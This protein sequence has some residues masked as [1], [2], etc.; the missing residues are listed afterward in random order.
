MSFKTEVIEVLS[1]SSSECSG[2]GQHRSILMMHHHDIN[3]DSSRHQAS[4]NHAG[5]VYTSSSSSDEAVQTPIHNRTRTAATIPTT[6]AST[7]STNS[8]IALSSTTL[9]NTTDESSNHNNHSGNTVTTTN[10]IVK[11]ATTSSVPTASSSLTSHQSSQ[12]TCETPS[13]KKKKNPIEENED[14]S[15]ELPSTSQK[16]LGRSVTNSQV[17][18]P[19]QNVHTVHMPPSSPL[20]AKNKTIATKP[21]KGNSPAS[22][23]LI[24]TPN[25]SATSTSSSSIKSASSSSNTLTPSSTLQTKTTPTPLRTNNN[26]SSDNPP[27]FISTPSS[28]NNNN[29]NNT[30]LLNQTPSSS[31]QYSPSSHQTSKS[32]PFHTPPNNQISPH[33]RLYLS[34]PRDSVTRTTPLS[35]SFDSSLNQHASQTDHGEHSC[36]IGSMH[37]ATLPTLCPKPKQFPIWYSQKI[38]QCIWSPLELMVPS[39]AETCPKNSICDTIEK[40]EAFE[41]FCLKIVK[42]PD[43]YRQDK[44]LEILHMFNLDLHQAKRFIKDHPMQITSQPLLTQEQSLKVFNALCQF[45]LYNGCLR[46][47]HRQVIPEVPYSTLICH[48]FLN[49]KNK[50]I[51]PKSLTRII[52]LG[53]RSI[54]QQQ[55]VSKF[56]NSDETSEEDEDDETYHDDNQSTQPSTLQTISARATRASETLHRHHPI[57]NHDN[58]DETSSSSS[59]E[60]VP[61]SSDN[62]ES[63]SS[64]EEDN[65]HDSRIKQTQ[66]LPHST[67]VHFNHSLHNSNNTRHHCT[68]VLANR[69]NTN[70]L[71]SSDSEETDI[72]SNEGENYTNGHTHVSA[73]EI[74]SYGSSSSAEEAMY[75]AISNEDSSSTTEVFNFEHNQMFELH[76]PTFE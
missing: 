49:K 20:V 42:N 58:E 45:Y 37:Q 44:A 2:I 64:S 28:S 43:D 50:T 31:P 73:S 6:N 51:I 74:N 11:P 65:Q 9:N 70:Y 25:A 19:S 71:L 24:T 66:S 26:H 23:P 57:T 68:S 18:R 59:D 55:Q 16:T 72:F 75:I 41:K 36:K 40:L 38:G 1:S 8:T 12:P 17:A 39:V 13:K 61:E 5:G 62:E 29:N 21:P 52:S 35:S 48:F 22:I 76:P 7:K 56:N 15:D 33:A 27:F 10:N 14:V 69:K 60:R 32:I 63:S 46:E 67:H 3:H 4:P 30:S 53:R 54:I 34:S 47:L